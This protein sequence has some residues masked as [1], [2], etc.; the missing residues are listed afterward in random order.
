MPMTATIVPGA[1]TPTAG[2]ETWASTFAIAT[3]IPG[4]R[5]VH[6]AASAESSP[7][8]S[9]IERTSRDILSSTTA[10]NPGSRSPK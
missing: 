3:A 8:C 2:T 4:L 7:A 5:P 1:V 10:A 6:D 9:P